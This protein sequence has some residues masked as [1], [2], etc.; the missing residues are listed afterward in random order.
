MRPRREAAGG[1]LAHGGQTSERGARGEARIAGPR[2]R[3]ASRATASHRAWH[4]CDPRRPGPKEAR[5]MIEKVN[6]AEKF[7]RFRTLWDPKIVAELN[8]QQVK[9]VRFKG[10]FVWH[11]HEAEDE[12]FL[13][14]RGAFVMEFRDRRVPVG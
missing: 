8:G 1:D 12:L 2:R 5:A 7:A 11:H 13:V 3:V 4:P 14:L 9:L 10:D 6:L